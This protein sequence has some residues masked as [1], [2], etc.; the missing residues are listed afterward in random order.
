MEQSAEAK[1]HAD[2]QSTR[3]TQSWTSVIRLRPKRARLA[4]VG[5]PVPLPRVYHSLIMLGDE[6]A[7][8]Q[9]PRTIVHGSEP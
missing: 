2:Q 1:G 8:T 7:S 5:C 3:R 9:Q 4:N 6:E